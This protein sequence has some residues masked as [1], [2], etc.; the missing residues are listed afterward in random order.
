[1]THD[2]ASLK[3]ALAHTPTRAVKAQLTRLVPFQHLVSSNPPDWLLTFGKPNR[4]NTAGIECVY[5]GENKEVAELE[6]VS[7]FS[8]LFGKRQPVTTYYADIVLGRVLDLTDPLILKALRLDAKELSKN[9]R[10]AKTPTATQLLGKA[11]SEM[12]HFSAIRYF[13]QAAAKKGQKGANFVIFR[14][15]VRAP[16]SVVILGPT[17]RPLQKWP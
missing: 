2:F 14:G 3:S 9:W 16:D 4:Y 8:R 15:S 12:G 7:Q 10:R 6:Y 11:V 13:S 1:M 5:F 17:R